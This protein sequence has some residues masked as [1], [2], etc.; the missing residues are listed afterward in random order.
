MR[1]LDSNIVIYATQTGFEY[2][3]PLLNDSN[4][5]ISEITKLEVLGFH[6]FDA[7]SKQ[8]MEVLF[9]VLQI[10][11]INST[12]IDRA[13]ELRQ[14]RKM[15]IGDSIVAAT[16]LIQGCEL[17]SRDARGFSGLG[18]TVVNPVL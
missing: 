17:I 13:V 5:Y 8:D 7:T 11:P 6:G 14:I 12:I 1:I 18:I 10:I 15:S 16:V 4:N 2:L 3:F 9:S